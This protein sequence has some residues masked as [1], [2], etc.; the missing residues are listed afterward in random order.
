[1]L[2]HAHHAREWYGSEHAVVKLRGQ[3]LR[4]AESLPDAARLRAAFAKVSTL[5][6]LETLLLETNNP[7]LQPL[8]QTP[9]AFDPGPR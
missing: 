3:L 5:A 1:M 7:R 9:V 8:S 6:D 4:Y 2:E